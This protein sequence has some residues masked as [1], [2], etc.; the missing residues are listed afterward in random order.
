MA[1]KEG[2]KPSA[3]FWG[4]SKKLLTALSGLGD[5]A[6]F[7]EW[8]KESGLPR[9]TA[10]RWIRRLEQEN[11]V[12]SERVKGHGQRR[13]VYTLSKSQEPKSLHPSDIAR[14]LEDLK[15]EFKRE[16][17]TEKDVAVVQASYLYDALAATNEAQTL[18]VRTAIEEPRRAARVLQEVF[19]PNLGKVMGQFL[20]ELQ[21]RRQ[22][23]EAIEAVYLTGRTQYHSGRW[24][25]RETSHL[26]GGKE[27]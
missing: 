10:A 5:S 18:A 25:L 19:G 3:A 16:A 2:R 13:V 12:K 24:I 9:A 7:T 20:R 1:R 22:L 4:P 27:R 21:K 8:I 17:V 14:F 26:V 11:V 23:R 6:G 15:E